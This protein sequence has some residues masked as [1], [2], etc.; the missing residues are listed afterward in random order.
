MT[1]TTEF[2]M[3]TSKWERYANQYP[4]QNTWDQ[5]VEKFEQYKTEMKSFD[6]E[7]MKRERNKENETEK[8]ED[9]GEIAMLYLGFLEAMEVLE[10]LDEIFKHGQL[11]YL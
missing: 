2:E 4:N 11:G 9:E 10:K 8:F 7:K 6:V 3:E 5:L 1:T